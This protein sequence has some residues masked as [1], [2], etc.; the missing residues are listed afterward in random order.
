MCIEMW[1]KEFLFHYNLFIIHCITH[2]HHLGACNKWVLNNV[3]IIIKW[4]SKVVPYIQCMKH[5]NI[6]S[7]TSDYLAN[8]LNWR[9]HVSLCESIWVTYWMKCFKQLP[10][11]I[12]SFEQ[13]FFCFSLLWLYNDSSCLSYPN[14]TVCNCH[15]DSLRNICDDL[16]IR[17]SWSIDAKV[18]PLSKCKNDERF[19]KIWNLPKIYIDIYRNV[20]WFLCTSSR[21][22]YIM[23]YSRSILLW[24]RTDND[25]I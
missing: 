15:D 11:Y 1:A 17:S 16:H 7:L 2:S 6:C 5:E 19:Q 18:V 25:L 3:I 13:F 12:S 23:V 14:K 9:A 21:Y 8:Q 24:N 4:D 22:F 10:S 20:V